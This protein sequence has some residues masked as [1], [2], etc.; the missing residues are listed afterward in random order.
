M[1]RLNLL[2]S[3]FVTILVVSAVSATSASAACRRVKPL[4]VS[5]YNERLA[6]F[7]AGAAAASGFVKTQGNGVP[8]PGDPGVQCY[9]VR[10][11]TEPSGWT[12]NT[13]TTPMAGTGAFI[14]IL[15]P[16]GIFGGAGLVR[17]AAAGGE[18]V[19]INPASFTSSNFRLSAEFVW[20]NP[21][22]LAIFGYNPNPEGGARLENI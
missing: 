22:T 5:T 17:K 16:C 1:I 14:K 7:C 3:L 8:V 12:N 11:A 6:G 2:A 20:N 10:T 18:P 13:C 21:Q 4:E 15:E 19:T 9:R